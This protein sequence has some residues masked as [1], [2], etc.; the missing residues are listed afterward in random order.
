MA[1]TM[2][3][4]MT[5]PDDAMT[6]DMADDMDD[7]SS[8]DTGQLDKATVM[9]W[10]REALSDLD[11]LKDTPGEGVVDPDAEPVTLRAIEAAARRA[12]EDA[13]GPLREAAKPKKAPAK[14]AAPKPEP[15]PTPA[16]ATESKIRR[17]LWGEA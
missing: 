9:G 2:V 11:V 8:D 1:W 10:V 5:T 6:D 7:E 14:K 13:M 4:I 12:V 15:E 3:A 17:L 16:P